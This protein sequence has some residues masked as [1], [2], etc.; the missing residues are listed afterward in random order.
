MTD[1]PPSPSRRDEDAA[2]GRRP[3]ATRGADAD[4]APGSPTPEPGPYL[5]RIGLDP[6]VDPAASD[7]PAR[8]LGVATDREALDRLVAA[9]LHAVPFETLW[10]AGA[11]DDEAT[12][13]G[14]DLA[15]PTLFEKVVER[16]RGGF[17]FELNGL[18][19]WL[20]S[21]LGFETDRVAGM[22]L[23]D[24]GAPTP[25]NHH[26]NLVHLDRPYLVD[27]GTGAPATRCP[28]PLDGTPVADERGTRWRVA[29]SDRPDCDHRLERRTV[30]G[31]ADADAGGSGGGDR[32]DAGD[33]AD[34][35]TTAYVLEDEP[36]SLS[37]F[38]ATCA[39]LSRAPE[40]TFTGD[41]VVVDRTPG[42]YRKLTADALVTVT[43]AGRTETPVEPDEWRDV[44][45]ERFDL[46]APRE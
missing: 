17:C 10:I 29:P 3:A 24:E 2:D 46:R 42:G 34:G 9:H 31:R 26:A 35:W 16:R 6:A 23:P 33:R 32:A 15:L 11:P 8:T 22:V 38:A 27:V 44:L 4:A 39:Y 30:G 36:R 19:G 41:P 18:F 1:G 25:A 45:R 5:R 37:Y 21:A 7:S 14:V 12:G 43:A 20:L 28:V 13:P 40:S